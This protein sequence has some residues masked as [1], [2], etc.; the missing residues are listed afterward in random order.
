MLSRQTRFSAYLAACAVAAM[1][2]VPAVSQAL[3]SDDESVSPDGGTVMVTAYGGV[4]GSAENV[5]VSYDTDGPSFDGPTTV[6]IPAGRS[7]VTFPVEV[8]P[9][10]PGESVW[11]GASSGSTF[12]VTNIWVE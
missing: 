3:W 7:S 8:G 10:F 6:V 4:P 9:G 1:L 12:S 5:P 11:V 2:A